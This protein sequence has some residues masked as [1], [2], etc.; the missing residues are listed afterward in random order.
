MEYAVQSEKIS[1]QD[2]KKYVDTFK[3][4][5][6]KTPNMICDNFQT[7]GNSNHGYVPLVASNVVYMEELK[8]L[9]FDKFMVD[10]QG[11]LK[12]QQLRNKE[13]FLLKK[14]NMNLVDEVMVGIIRSEK[15]LA[16]IKGLVKSYFMKVM[17][18]K[19]YENGGCHGQM[20]EEF[21]NLVFKT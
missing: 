6:R 19:E 15:G 4:Y 7:V 14:K 10:Q 1:I 16:A 12:E 18:D 8:K 5:Q 9:M 2:G 20:Q 13:E 21:E 11:L 3:A 17:Q